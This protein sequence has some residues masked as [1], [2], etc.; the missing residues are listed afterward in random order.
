M[1]GRLL[2]RLHIQTPWLRRYPLELSGGELQRLCIARAL[3]PRT[4]Y[5]LCD[6]ITAMLDSITQAQIWNF[7][8]EESRRREL[9]ILVVSHNGALLRRLCNRIVTLPPARGPRDSTWAE[10]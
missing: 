7:L 3:G 10:R 1:D 9:G 2:E 8:L 4:R 5:L 6:E